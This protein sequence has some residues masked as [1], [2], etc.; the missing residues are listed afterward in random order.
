MFCEI[1]VHYFVYFDAGHGFIGHIMLTCRSD[2]YYNQGYSKS[3]IGIIDE[4]LE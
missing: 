4:G 3:R 1:K 2:K